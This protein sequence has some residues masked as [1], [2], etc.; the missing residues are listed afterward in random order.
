MI[1]I[2]DILKPQIWLEFINYVINSDLQLQRAFKLLLHTG[3]CIFRFIF[4]TALRT[5][6]ASY[7]AVECLYVNSCDWPTTQAGVYQNG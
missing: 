6:S 2:K 5:F 1:R 3:K 4:F 7:A